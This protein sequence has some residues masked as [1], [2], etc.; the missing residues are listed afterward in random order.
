[1]QI[2]HRVLHPARLVFKFPGALY[3]RNT[4]SFNVSPSP[5][6]HH[7]AHIWGAHGSCLPQAWFHE[8][9]WIISAC[10][11]P[12]AVSTRSH[13]QLGREFLPSTSGD[14]PEL[15]CMRIIIFLSAHVHQCMYGRNTFQSE[16]GVSAEE[17]RTPGGL[18]TH[19]GNSTSPQHLRVSDPYALRFF[20]ADLVST[21]PH[22]VAAYLCI[23]WQRSGQQRRHV[24]TVRPTTFNFKC[25]GLQATA[26]NYT[27]IDKGTYG[28]SLDLLA[29][30]H[31][32]HDGIALRILHDSPFCA[33]GYDHGLC[34]QPTKLDRRRMSNAQESPAVLRIRQPMIWLGSSLCSGCSM[35][36]I[37]APSSHR[38]QLSS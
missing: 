3:G 23:P 13:V 4:Q 36:T 14:A 26:Y 2:T 29:N 27:I 1:M 11:L 5:V 21:T 6:F 30:D 15:H 34:F 25:P 28:F 19:A 32:N 38:R 33:I 18:S 8:N 16:A 17:R 7:Y 24:H 35:P 10:S 9:T 20:G 37:D 31:S 12:C 22:I